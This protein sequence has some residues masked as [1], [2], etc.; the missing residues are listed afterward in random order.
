MNSRILSAQR[1]HPVRRLRAALAIWRNARARPSGE[2]VYVIYL[3]L[4][5]ALVAVAP[6]ARAIW[7]SMTSPE[8]VAALT[9]A[10]A[11]QVAMFAVAAL[12][13]GALFAGRDRGPAL[14]PPFLI[15][16]FVTSDVRRSRVF[17]GPLLRSAGVVVATATV[18]GGLIAVSLASHGLVAPLHATV[19]IIASALIGII[20]AMLWLAGQALPRTATFLALGVLALGTVTASVPTLVPFTPWGWFGLL[21]SGDGSLQALAGLWALTLALCA[22]APTLLN[23]LRFAELSAQ[24]L[25]WQSAMTHATGM[26][27]A[28]A[29]TVYQLRP[30]IGRRIRAVRSAGRLPLT[31]LVR[32]A[33]GAVRTPGRLL[34]G[35]LTLAAA[36]VLIAVASAPLAPGWMLGTLAG[37]IAFAGMGPLTDGIRHATS[38]ASDFALY[39]IGDERLLAN[40]ALFPIAVAAVVLVGAAGACAVIMGI[41][42]LAPLVSSFAVGM[43][44]IAARIATALKGALPVALLTPMPTPMGDLGAAVRLAWALDGLLFAALAG[45]AA[46]VVFESP[47]LLAG[48]AVAVG[49]IGVSRWRHRR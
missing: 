11:R 17:R 24:S 26:D 42:V 9:S 49:G 25:R 28:S 21:Y 43:L 20:T 29:T 46:V 35:I 44:A 31:F 5:V 4:M 19:F 40:H 48:V 32:D 3:A 6:V 34:T 10:T 30:G 15:H 27:F 38:V 36:G 37:I 12:W 14:R 22:A 47:L 45:V 7:V 39:G 8:V 33:V 23:R 13:A 41:S 2:R 18:I 16:A 1:R